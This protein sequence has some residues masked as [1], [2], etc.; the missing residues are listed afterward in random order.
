[1]GGSRSDAPGLGHNVTHNL[2]VTRST[3]GCVYDPHIKQLL[4][5]GRTSTASVQDKAQ[6][7]AA[8]WTS[9]CGGPN[10]FKSSP[11]KRP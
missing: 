9:T 8:G 6:H 1:M 3:L 4:Q 10:M 7:Y 2:V 11:A 5:P